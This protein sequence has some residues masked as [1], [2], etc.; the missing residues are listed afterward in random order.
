MIAKEKQLIVDENSPF[1]NTKG[2]SFKAFPSDLSKVRKYA[3]YCIRFM[4]EKYKEK[5]LLEQQLSEIIKNAIKHGNHEDPKKKV[6][7]WFRANRKK[8]Y[9]HFIVEDEG[10]GFQD[11]EKWNE[12]YKKRN[13]AIA[14]H[15]YEEMLKYINYKTPHSTET[16]GGNA[17]FAAIE[18]WNGGIIYNQKKNKV[19]VIRFF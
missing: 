10:E 17:L 12:F 1:F 14:S 9:I 2:M 4:P 3:L 13:H 18:Y 15:N 7:V 19:S 6:K 8:R 5:N 11:L 16:D